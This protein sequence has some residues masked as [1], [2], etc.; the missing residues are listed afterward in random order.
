LLIRADEVI[1]VN[2]AW[3]LLRKLGAGVLAGVALHAPLVLAHESSS[4]P[5]IGFLS[6]CARSFDEQGFKDGLRELGYIDGKSILI[7]WRRFQE[8]PAQLRRAAD[9]L[10]RSKVD[11]VV[12]CATPAT[13]AALDATKTIPIVFTAT[14]DPVATGLVASLANPGA[15]AT[16]VSIQA[17]ELSTKRLDLLSQ[18]APQARR[19]AY[20]GN[21]SSPVPT[22]QP[23]KAAAKT[24]NIRLQTY[25][26]RNAREVDATL[27]A[28]PWSSI[29][30]VLIGADVVALA[31]AERIAQAVLKARLPA[32]FPWRQF[33]EHGVLMSYGPD[34]RELMRRGAYYVDRI[35]KGSRPSDLPVEQV[36]KV[37]L[38]IDLRVAREMK[39][40]VPSELLYRADEVIK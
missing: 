17:P 30:G 3:L 12:T 29:D 28:V 5:R 15:N 19:V 14:G 26:I 1:R 9:E 39:I 31:Q 25:N 20:I 40:N 18:L 4:V 22:L 24:L 38:I 34:S 35:L 13:R 27:H 21:L 36:S 16:G 37:N 32:V 2:T 10:V 33:H 11:I 23:L 6:Y 8:N 7:E